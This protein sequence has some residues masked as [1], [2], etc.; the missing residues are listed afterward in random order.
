LLTITVLIGSHG[1]RVLMAGETGR[2]APGPQECE[3]VRDPE[4]AARGEPCCCRIE[5]K[6]ILTIKNKCAILITGW[7][8][9][10]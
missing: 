3:K 6:G 7:L 5:D 4:R 2:Y 8:H 1:A 9:S 10:I